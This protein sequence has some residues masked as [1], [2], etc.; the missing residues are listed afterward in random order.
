MKRKP[1]YEWRILAH[2]DGGAKPL[3]LRFTPHARHCFDE[4]VIDDWFHLEQMSDRH[5][6]III[7][8]IHIDAVIRANGVE[9][10]GWDDAE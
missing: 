10:S 2:P 7:G 8:D 5:W 4:L 9:V 1:G 3:D 6:H